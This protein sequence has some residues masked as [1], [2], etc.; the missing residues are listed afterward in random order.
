MATRQALSHP[1]LP[2]TFEAGQDL[3]N[4]KNRFVSIAADQQIDPTPATGAGY[5]G[6]LYDLDS[7]TSGGAAG[8]ECYVLCEG[9]G[10]IEVAEAINAGQEISSAGASGKGAVVASGE[11]IL[12]IALETASADG[13]LISCLIV[14]GGLK[15]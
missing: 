10:V 13:Q 8:D 12:A 7:D 9:V 11:R 2:L 14:H 4:Y 5:V 3:T 6:I 15:A 1:V